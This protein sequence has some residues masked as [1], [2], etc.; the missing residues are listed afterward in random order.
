MSL[1]LKVFLNMSAF[2]LVTY[3]VIHRSFSSRAFLNIFAYW[4]V[5]NYFV[6]RIPNFCLEHFIQTP[7]RSSLAKKYEAEYGAEFFHDISNP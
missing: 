7:F 2:G 3:C 5:G 6:A 1:S 4:F